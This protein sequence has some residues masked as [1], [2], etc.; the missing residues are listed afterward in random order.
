M[1]LPVRGRVHGSSGELEGPLPQLEGQQMLVL[2]EPDETVPSVD[3]LRD[4][5]DEWVL[6]GPHGPIEDEGEPEFP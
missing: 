6:R 2:V 5:W 4:A 3:E 1:S